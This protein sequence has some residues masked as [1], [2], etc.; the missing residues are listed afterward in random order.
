MRQ[1]RGFHM[2]QVDPFVHSYCLVSTMGISCDG[3]PPRVLGIP[4]PG[5]LI[6]VLSIMFTEAACISEEIVWRVISSM[7]LD[8]KR[9]LSMWRTQESHYWEFCALR[10]PDFHPGA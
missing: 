8:F 4:L 5:L 1:A 3:I 7:G 6:M 10:V 2:I 9:E